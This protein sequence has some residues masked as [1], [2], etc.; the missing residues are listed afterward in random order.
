[1]SAA[2]VLD[3][4]VG[5]LIGPVLGR[6]VRFHCARADL[7]IDRLSDAVLIT[8]A[9]AA[10]IED[11]AIDGRIRCVVEARPGCVGLSVGPLVVGGARR[12]IDASAFDHLGPVLSALAD[13]LEPRAGSDG[14]HLTIEIRSRHRG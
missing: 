12:F 10:G 3:I 11:V 14:D 1:M 6:V 9:I 13:T 4:P 8:D 7:E 5:P 2:T